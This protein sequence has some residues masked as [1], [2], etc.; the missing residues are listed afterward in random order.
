MFVALISRPPPTRARTIDWSAMKTPRHNSYD[1]SY[2]EHRYLLR[3]MLIMFLLFI[4]P[5][6]L[7][8]AYLIF[9]PGSFGHDIT[10]PA[11]DF[12]SWQ[13]GR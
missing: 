8:I 2:D 5:G 13:P 7:L 4:L 11:F 6:A 12:S 1:D 9:N 10:P 3:L